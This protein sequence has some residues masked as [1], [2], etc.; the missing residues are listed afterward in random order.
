MRLEYETAG[1]SESNFAAEPFQQFD[2][3]FNAAVAAEVY[4]P[5][6][7]VVSTVDHDGQPWSRYV[8]LKAV[9]GAGFEFFT[10]YESN[11]SAQLDGQPRAS[12]TFGWLELHRQVNIAGTVE[13]VSEA[14]SDAYWAVRTRGSQLGGWASPQ[15]RPITGRSELTDRYEEI[16]QRFGDDGV[17]RP[18]HWGGWRVVPH[19]VEFWQGR[20]NRMHDRLRYVRTDPSSWDL[21]RLAP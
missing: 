3:W 8:L 21:I 11:K 19:T 16:E 5:N 12:I 10:N 20:Q 1:I 15:S 6:A 7:M 18:P 17:P 13:R 4:E 9:S 2:E 14:D